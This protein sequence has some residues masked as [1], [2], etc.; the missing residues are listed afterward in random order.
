L[1]LSDTEATEIRAILDLKA[2]GWAEGDI[3]R[4][5]KISRATYFRRLA[6]AEAVK[7]KR[8]LAVL[9]VSVAGGSPED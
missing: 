8:P 4:A 3:V 1:R 5:L 6:K 9:P 2:R 7:R